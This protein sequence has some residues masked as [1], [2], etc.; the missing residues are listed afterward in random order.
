MK[1]KKRK[2]LVDYSSQAHNCGKGIIK[3]LKDDRAP[4][5]DVKVYTTEEKGGSMQYQGL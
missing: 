2:E 3:V 5:P 1:K 4:K